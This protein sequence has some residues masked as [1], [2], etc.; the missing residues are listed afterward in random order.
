MVVVL[1]QDHETLLGESTEVASHDAFGCT[2]GSSDGTDITTGVGGDVCEHHYVLAVLALHQ[3]LTEKP[4]CADT[5]AQGRGEC[6]VVPSRL[7]GPRVQGSERQQDGGGET[8]GSYCGTRQVA[9]LG[10][11]SSTRPARPVTGCG[12]G[13]SASQLRKKGTPSLTCCFTGRRTLT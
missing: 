7:G 6:G 11:V 1:E 2:D 3:V 12:A 4:G 9:L 5:E 10:Y 13:C 8:D